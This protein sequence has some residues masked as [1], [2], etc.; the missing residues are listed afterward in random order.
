MAKQLQNPGIFVSFFIYIPS[1]P[2]IV[3]T[4]FSKQTL[5]TPPILV[6]TTFAKIIVNPVP[7]YL[8]PLDRE[9]SFMP[10]R[11]D[12]L[13]GLLIAIIKIMSTGIFKIS[14]HILSCQSGELCQ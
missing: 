5:L 12:W 10:F 3:I 7:I 2:Q 14:P 1:L 4:A 13:D 9:N 6:P 8:L 11:T